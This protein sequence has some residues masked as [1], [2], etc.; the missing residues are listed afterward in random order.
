MFF[1]CLEERR[2][3]ETD[4]RHGEMPRNVVERD[5]RKKKNTSRDL[6]GKEK[7]ETI[8]FRMVL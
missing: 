4:R 6:A 2:G 1:R 7:W 5:E 8:V 3:L